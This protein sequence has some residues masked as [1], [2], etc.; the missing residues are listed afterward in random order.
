MAQGRGRGNHHH[1]VLG[2]GLRILKFTW[3][4]HTQALFHENMPG[5]LVDTGHRCFK[6]PCGSAGPAALPQAG[7]SLQ[8][9]TDKSP[10]AHRNR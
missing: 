6:G 4:P 5:T 3:H 8:H 1:Q 9:F 7:C 10:E 2:K